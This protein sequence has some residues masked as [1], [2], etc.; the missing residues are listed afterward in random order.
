MKSLA[1]VITKAPFGTIHAAEAI[2]L[3]NGATS[4][5]HHVSL[6]LVGDGVL[7]AKKGQKAE[8]TG[9]TSLSPLLEK[10]ASAARA[11][12]LADLNSAKQRGLSQGDFGEGIELVE[13]DTIFSAIG[14]SQRITIF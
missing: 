9:W 8:E 3:A 11:R 5:G 12:V 10:M 4:Y 6:L 13:R 2:R 1:I 7:V 14:N